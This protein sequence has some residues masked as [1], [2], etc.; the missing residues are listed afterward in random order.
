M[1][2]VPT[3]I[4]HTVIAME[5]V[6]RWRRRRAQH[7]DARCGS[8]PGSRRRRPGARGTAP[9]LHRPPGPAL[10]A[11]F[12]GWKDSV[13]GLT[14]MPERIPFFDAANVKRELAVAE[15]TGPD[16]RRRRRL[17]PARPNGR[18]PWPV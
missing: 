5:I 2:R 11:A 12:W 3:F 7:A 15:P 9:G 6:G 8:L 16:R 1:D 18:R 14:T 10:C 4:D 13:G 17:A